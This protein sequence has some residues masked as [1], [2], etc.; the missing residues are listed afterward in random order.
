MLIYF[1]RAGPHKSNVLVEVVAVYSN[2]FFGSQIEYIGSRLIFGGILLA[3]TEYWIFR[4]QLAEN[5]I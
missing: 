1:P 3:E 2:L 4:K 5:Q